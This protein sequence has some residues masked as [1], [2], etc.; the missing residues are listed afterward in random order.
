[1][2]E[3]KKK[4][5]FLRPGWYRVGRV[6]KKMKRKQV[7]RK[8]KGGDSKIRMKER[9]Y[10]AKPST[11]WGSDKRIRN[12]IQGE[13][14]VRIENLKQLNNLKKGDCIIIASVGKKKREE[15]KKKAGEMGIKILNRYYTK[16]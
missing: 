8:A 6:G 14:F 9:G 10:A 12:K 1:M 16:K 7:W 2:V 5:L 15:I 11:G 13:S 3:K 4:P